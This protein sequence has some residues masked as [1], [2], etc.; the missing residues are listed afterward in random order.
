[1]NPTCT[2]HLAS[3]S[4]AHLDVLQRL[5]LFLLNKVV[6]V[7]DSGGSSQK[8][9]QNPLNPRHAGKLDIVL[10]ELGISE[11]GSACTMDADEPVKDDIL[12]SLGVGGGFDTSSQNMIMDDCNLSEH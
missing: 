10:L 4:L 11:M 6:E 7:A 9:R 2:S 8:N 5:E 3:R 1:M 12:N